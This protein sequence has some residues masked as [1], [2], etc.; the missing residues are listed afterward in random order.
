VWCVLLVGIFTNL[1]VTYPWTG[2]V[3]QVGDTAVMANREWSTGGF[4]RV[5]GFSRT[6]FDAAICIILLGFYLVITGPRLAARASIWLL[7]GAAVVL[8]T[9]KATIGVFIV[10]TPMLPLIMA[11][12]R[13]HASRFARKIVPCATLGAVAVVGLAAPVITSQIDLP[14]LETGTL[15]HLMFA[16][17]ID[18]AWSTWPTAWSLLDSWQIVLGRGVGGIGAAQSYFEL[19]RSSP[20]DN[21]FVYLY[22]TAG[23][24]A[25]AL[26][27]YVA[28]LCWKLDLASTAS[29]LCYCVLLFLFVDG[30]T[31]N[32][33]ECAPALAV[34]GAACVAALHESRHAQAVHGVTR[35]A[36]W[37]QRR[38]GPP[39]AVRSDMV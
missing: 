31:T 9:T 38:R 24:P 3:M 29:R 12:P 18:R 39:A 7:T 25:A 23:L 10:A 1:F 4:A 35:D 28:G 21:L 16:S 15:E 19:A 14:L 6:S 36:V 8:T 17:L 20:A 33:I 22:V 34:I 32:V 27:C 5:S 26:Y 13:P 2:M 30:L 11:T 37:S